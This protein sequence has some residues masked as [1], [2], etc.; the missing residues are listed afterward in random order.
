MLDTVLVRLARAVQLIA[1][2]V[3]QPRRLDHPERHRPVDLGAQL[4][5]P[6]EFAHDTSAGLSP[7]MPSGAT[8]N[9]ARPP[10][11]MARP[12]PNSSCSAAYVPGTASPSMARWPSVRDVEK[13]ERAGLDGLLDDA[14]HGRDVVPGGLLVAGAA[15]AHRVPANSAV[16]DLR[17][18][19]DCEITL[20]DGVEV[21]GEA[22]PLPC[23]AFGQGAARNVLDALHQL[24]EPLFASR[25]SPVRSPRR[26]C[27][28]PPS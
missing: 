14:R 15:V 26:S 27:R 23:D 11:A 17:A 7:A 16:G 19:V 13:P 22:F 5:H 21:L 4:G 1:P 3:G 18:E 2:Q 20:L 6:V 8:S 28:R 9:T 12:S 24:D 10:A 25:A